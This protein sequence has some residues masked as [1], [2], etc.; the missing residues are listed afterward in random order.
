[1]YSGFETAEECRENALKFVNE[2]AWISL[3]DAPPWEHDLII[4]IDKRTGYFSVNRR[5][6]NG[7]NWHA[8]HWRFITHPISGKQV[9]H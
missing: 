5:I 6:A 1:M 8:T 9:D 4:T 7:W 2:H 3:D